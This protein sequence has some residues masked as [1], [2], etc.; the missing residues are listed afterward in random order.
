MP[1]RSWGKREDLQAKTK[2]IRLINHIGI[3]VFVQVLSSNSCF[4]C[5][6]SYILNRLSFLVD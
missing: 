1:L 3:F 4:V 6:C 5:L 2:K